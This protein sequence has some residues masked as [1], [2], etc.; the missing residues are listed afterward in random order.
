M[1]VSVLG[2]FN[3]DILAYICRIVSVIDRGYKAIIPEIVSYGNLSR[4]S[5]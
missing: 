5:L 3:L 2:P 4:C 1:A